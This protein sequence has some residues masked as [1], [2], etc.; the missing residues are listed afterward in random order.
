MKSKPSHIKLQHLHDILHAK[1]NLYLSRIKLNK[2]KVYI[3]KRFF[4][5]S[6]SNYEFVALSKQVPIKKRNRRKET[7]FIRELN[8][9]IF[10]NSV[11]NKQDSGFLE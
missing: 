2:I 5:K 4:Q 7:S 1:P 11:G 3:T 8:I 6:S 9:V 10:L